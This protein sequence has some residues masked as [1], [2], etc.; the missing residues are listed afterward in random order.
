MARLPQTIKLRGICRNGAGTANRLLLNGEELSPD[1]S[2]QLRNHSPDG[3]NW[4]YGGSG[5]AQSAL[6][7]CL[8]LFPPLNAIGWYQPFKFSIV[9]GLPQADFV[10]TVELDPFWRKIGPVQHY[11]AQV[12]LESSGRELQQAAYGLWAPSPSEARRLVEQYALDVYPVL[13]WGL[14]REVDWIEVLAVTP[15]D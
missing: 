7:I 6:A 10:G 1:L 5:P 12:R 11:S 15:D 13:H 4:G 8:A 2:L 14:Y 9:A 3:F